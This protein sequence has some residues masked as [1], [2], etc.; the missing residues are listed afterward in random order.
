MVYPGAMHTRFEHS[1]GVMHVATRMFDEIVKRRSAFLKSE[2]SFTDGGL[3]RDR[4]LVRLAALL[5]DVGHAPFSHVA[6]GLMVKD[7]DERDYKHEN[8]SAAA[9]KYFMK[10]VIEDHPMNQNYHIKVQDIAD[11]L[12]G[13]PAVGRS[14]LWRSLVSGQLDADRADYLL[15]D[16]HHIGVAY[17]RYDLNRLLVTMTVAIDPET[18]SPVLAVEEGGSHAD[19][20]LIVARYMMFTQVYFQ[21]TRQAYG[22]H[23]SEAIK[24]LL[25]QA[26]KGD[27]LEQDLRVFM[28]TP[29]HFKGVYLENAGPSWLR[30]DFSSSKS[31]QNPCICH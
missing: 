28:K 10:D 16:S 13:K 2:F 12:D 30:G 27:N 1:L 5:H 24:S 18:N 14:F 7:S 20:G 31:S 29:S 23:L 15:R 11:F 22:H 26:Q 3:E 17:G 6:E 19:E 25:A 4:V 8:Y 21:H 9:V